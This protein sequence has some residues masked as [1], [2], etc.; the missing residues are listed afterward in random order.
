MP[1]PEAPIIEIISFG[2]ANPVTLLRICFID[3]PPMFLTLILYSGLY[4][5]LMLSDSTM[6]FLAF[7]KLNLSSFVKGTQKLRFL[8]VMRILSFLL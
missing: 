6:D 1:L 8:Q 4:V 7:Y 5:G 2:F 3:F